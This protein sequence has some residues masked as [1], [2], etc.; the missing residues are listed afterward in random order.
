MV[1]IRSRHGSYLKDYNMSTKEILMATSAAATGIT[2][3]GGY[4]EGF[5]GQTSSKTITFG[6]S[7]TGGI[8]T[9]AS[10]GDLVLVFFATGSTT[11]RTLTVSG[12]T[13]IKRQSVPDTYDTNLVTAY[14]FQTST[15]DTSVVL[16]GGTGNSADAGT[17]IIQVWRG[18]IDVSQKGLPVGVDVL[19]VFDYSDVTAA[20]TILANPPSVTLA[21]G[22]QL[23]GTVVVACGAGAHNQG[24]QTYSSSDLSGFVSIGAN[25]TNDSTIGAGYITGLSNETVNPAAFTFSGTDNTQFSNV[26][27]TLVLWPDE[28]FPTVSGSDLNTNTGTNATGYIPAG[29]AVGDIIVAFVY[30]NSESAMLATGWTR[31]NYNSPSILIK[32]STSTYG[33]RTS[34]TFT[35][36]S[37]VGSQNFTVFTASVR[38]GSYVSSNGRYTRSQTTT[39][40]ATPTST[41]PGLVLGTGAANFY[42]NYWPVY[43]VAQVP[44]NFKAYDNELQSNNSVGSAEHYYEGTLG[45][46]LNRAPTG[47]VTV[48]A[49][50][51]D[52]YDDNL[53]EAGVAF[54]SYV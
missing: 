48:A 49:Y 47:N 34:Q 11:Q 33:T 41:L 6:G 52:P 44:A 28:Q 36:Q 4:S 29:T 9:S 37:P 39:T 14:K 8:D 16:T 35:Q 20:S 2:F 21:N 42:F 26:S 53:T 30:G 43:A 46:G 1:R 10:E 19:S 25:D 13:I 32:T 38:N 50:V 27:I 31:V 7:L 23:E 40:T 51:P 18:V 12:Y 54:F 5:I 45:A 3:V 17:I 24:V 22:P 15:P